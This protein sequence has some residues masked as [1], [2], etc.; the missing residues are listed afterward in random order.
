M[1]GDQTGLELT[2]KAAVEDVFSSLQERERWT[3]NLHLIATYSVYAGLDHL[4]DS[5]VL[6][7]LCLRKGSGFD[8]RNVAYRRAG[9]ELRTMKGQTLKSECLALLQSRVVNDSDVIRAWSSVL[10]H[11]AMSKVLLRLRREG[12]PNIRLFLDTFQEDVMSEGRTHLDQLLDEAAGDPRNA[13]TSPE[14]AALVCSA[15]LVLRSMDLHC[16]D[17]VAWGHMLNAVFPEVERMCAQTLGPI[18]S[19]PTKIRPHART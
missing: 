12:Y 13:R 10:I 1:A 4:D 7:I 3:S 9:E 2:M 18:R 8:I 15:R 16:H 14:E 6:E 17:K 5:E 11:Q 19:K